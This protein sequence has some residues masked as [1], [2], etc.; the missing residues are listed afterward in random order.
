MSD[1]HPAPI[2]DVVP[3][4]GIALDNVTVVIPTFNESDN[5]P[6]MAETIFALYPA[7]HLL[8]VDDHSPDGTAQ[9]VRRL[10]SR[11]PNLLLLECL[12]DP[13]FGRSYRDGFCQTLAQTWC[14]AL[15]TM[16]ADFS[17]D[18]AAIQHLVEKL[19]ENDAVIGSRYVAGGGVD[20]WGLH[21]RLLSRFANLYVRAVLRIPLRDVTSGFMAIRR[22]LLERVRLDHLQSEGYA[23][24]VDLKLALVSLDPRMA[25]HPITFRERRE[26]QSKMSGKKIWESIWLPWRLRL[27]VKRL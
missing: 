3:K 1:P 5:I 22:D 24:L 20:N 9:L 27:R 4:G 12:R 26:G 8:I 23:F 14:A 10:Q 21:R 19:S 15:V 11:Y 6:E 25:E 16:D 2:R 18:P 13:G 7:I 17:H